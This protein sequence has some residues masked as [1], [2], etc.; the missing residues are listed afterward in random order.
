MTRKEFEAII[1]IGDV[2]SYREKHYFFK[3]YLNCHYQHDKCPCCSGYIVLEDSSGPCQECFTL[4][5]SD[6]MIFDYVIPANYMPKE[7]FE[8]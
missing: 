4:A 7:L 3:G 8:I 6:E 5:D 1:N 2:I